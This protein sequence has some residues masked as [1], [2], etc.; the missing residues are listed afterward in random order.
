MKSMRMFALALAGLALLGRETAAA[1]DG[2]LGFRTIAS[3]DELQREKAFDAAI[4]PADLRSWMEQMSSEPNQVG[5]PHDKANAE[6]MLAKFKEWGWEARIETF[7]VLY[8]T[9]KS[10]AVELVAP[11]AFKARL[12]EPAVDGDRTSSRAAGALPPYNIYCA[13]GDVTADLVYVNFGLPADY[14]EL[15]RRGID[16]KG[17]IVIA[18]YGASWRG[19]KPKLAQEHGAVG[20][21]IYSDPHEEG[22]WSGDVYPKGAYRPDDGVQRGSVADITQYS[23]DPL[24]PGIGATKDAKRLKIED[25]PTILKIP[26]VP[27]SSADARPLLAA[28]DGPVAPAGWRGA[29]AFTYHVGPGPAKVHLAIASDWSL[30]TIYDVIAVMKG[31]D[32]PDQWVVRGNHHDGWVFGAWDPLAGNVAVMA[33]AKAIGALAK[34][35]WRPRRTLVYASWDGEEPGLL[36]ST[37]WAE[38]HAEELQKKVVLYVNSDTNGRG[39]LFAGGSHSYQHL[40]NEVAGAVLDPETGATILD[41]WRARVKVAGVERRLPEAIPVQDEELMIKAANAGG[42]MPISALGSGSDYT[43]FLEHLGVASINLGYG[44][45]DA[46]GG[47]YHSTYDSFDHFIRFGDPKFVYGVSLAETAG[48]LVL[49]AANADVLPMRMGDLADSVA[50]YITEVEKLTET[51]REDTAKLNGLVDE[52]AFKLAAD[53]QEARLAPSVP[54]DVP[55]LAFEA[56]DRAA[57]RIKKCAKTYDDAFA[58]ASATDFK[59]SNADLARING[60]LQGLEHALSSERGLPG[61][62]W[63]KHMLYA[64]GLYTGYAAKTLP[65]VREAVELRRWPDAIDYISVVA[66][67][68]NKASSR[69]DEATEALTPRPG[70]QAGAGKSA[71]PPPPPPS[72]S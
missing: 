52:G 54:A 8:P 39:F 43:P 64:P 16:V 46:D 31:S 68:L 66:D 6:F 48:R 29:L 42:D 49:R 67:V 34:T 60:I 55:M 12:S 21:I 9:P 13:D 37:E 57:S 11:S 63:Y 27:I 44:G 23:G 51:E 47:I 18:R 45:E 72:D 40:L 53:P 59:F 1:P 19:L 41:R 14:A 28:L 32:F 56:L 30:K 3:A 69:M 20:C 62:A 22:Y 71:G 7:E 17:K 10:M 70:K 33:E 2:L 15:D 65:A 24:T 50:R 36:G 61:R 25:A 58:R 5:S 4:D 35:G 26:V 38:T